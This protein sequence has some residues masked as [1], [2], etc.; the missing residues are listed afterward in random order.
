MVAPLLLHPPTCHGCLALNPWII[1]WLDMSSVGRSIISLVCKQWYQMCPPSTRT[2]GSCTHAHT[3]LS[4]AGANSGRLPQIKVGSRVK[5][6]VFGLGHKAGDIGLVTEYHSETRP[7]EHSLCRGCTCR[8]SFPGGDATLY[9]HEVQYLPGDPV[10]GLC[11]VPVECDRDDRFWCDVRQSAHF[12]LQQWS[13]GELGEAFATLFFDEVRVGGYRIVSFGMG[14]SFELAHSDNV[15]EI[16]RCWECLHTL[17]VLAKSGCEH[18]VDPNTGM[19]LVRQAKCLN[20]LPSL[21]PPRVVAFVKTLV[22][23]T[24]EIDAAVQPADPPTLSQW[25]ITL[26]LQGESPARLLTVASLVS[27]DWAAAAR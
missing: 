17:A 24:L 12:A 11:E 10:S 2:F 4:C 25:V 6:L 13:T 26:A 7:A 9:A 21:V 22:L 18:D 8:V 5:S 27:K 15:Q 1:D 23:S 16:E 3:A 20:V 19:V 14:E